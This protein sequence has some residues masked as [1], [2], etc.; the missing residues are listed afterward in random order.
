MF[1]DI[2]KEKYCT[3]RW[4]TEV[5]HEKRLD[6]VDSVFCLYRKILLII[7]MAKK[8]K[9]RKHPFCNFCILSTLT[10]GSPKP[11]Q[12]WDKEEV[13]G[14]SLTSLFPGFFPVCHKWLEYS[15]WNGSC[16][17]EARWWWTRQIVI[18]S[19]SPLFQW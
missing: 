19:F 1:T 6:L 16:S 8:K 2:K 5:K 18:V 4:Y 10:F 12:I 13:V 11:V 15:D 9:K 14:E 3:M 7:E 17:Q